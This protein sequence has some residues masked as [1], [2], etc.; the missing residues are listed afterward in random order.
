MTNPAAAMSDEEVRESVR[1]NLGDLVPWLIKFKQW[2][3]YPQRKM[4]PSPSASSSQKP[5][6]QPMDLMG[7]FKYMTTHLDVMREYI[8]YSASSMN[9][10]KKVSI[11]KA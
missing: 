6:D 1:Q 7:V 11:L 8:D 5:I 3:E 4:G 2:K 10:Q 9:D